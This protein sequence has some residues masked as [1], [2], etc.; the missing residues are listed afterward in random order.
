MDVGDSSAV[1]SL[2]S[3]LLEK[4]KKIDI[5]V[6]NA[7]ITRDN[8]FIRM[9]ESEWHDVINTNLNSAFYFSLPIIKRMIQNRY[10]PTHSKYILFSRIRLSKGGY[11]CFLRL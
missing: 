1:A 10:F 6:N 7:G 4:Y 11:G 5:L 2:C 9:K 3:S 8:L